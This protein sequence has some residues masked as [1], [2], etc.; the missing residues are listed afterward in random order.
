MDVRIGEP[1]I[2]FEKGTNIVSKIFLIDST[3]NSKEISHRSLINPLHERTPGIIVKF[4]HTFQNI[5]RLIWNRV[6]IES[7]FD[8]N[9]VYS[10]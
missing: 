9:S 5:R 10:L 8:I 7:K 4:S 3:F 2:L 6:E 1:V